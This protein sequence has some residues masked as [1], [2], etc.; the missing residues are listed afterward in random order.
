[1][2]WEFEPEAMPR[3]DEL[4]QGQMLNHIPGMGPPL[5]TIRPDF[6]LTQFQTPGFFMNELRFYDSLQNQRQEK[7]DVPN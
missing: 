3:A 1:M 7:L 2:L 5:E 6:V 4:A